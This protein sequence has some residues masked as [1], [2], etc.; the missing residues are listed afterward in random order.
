MCRH[1]RFICVDVS[2]RHSGADGPRDAVN[3]GGDSGGDGDRYTCGDVGMLATE[4]LNMDGCNDDGGK[5][6]GNQTYDHLHQ[7]GDVVWNGGDGCGFA[8][9][10]R[11]CFFTLRS[12]AIVS[13]ACFIRFDEISV[14]CIRRRVHCMSQVRRYAHEIKDKFTSQCM[15]LS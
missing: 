10:V 14:A 11:M 8:W 1:S 6:P 2:A 12:F 5:L 4:Q 9:H 13:T 7:V 15:L 3:G